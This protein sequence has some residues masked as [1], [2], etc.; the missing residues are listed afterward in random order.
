MTAHKFSKEHKK[1]LGSLKYEGVRNKDSV[2]AFEGMNPDLSEEAKRVGRVQPELICEYVGTGAKAYAERHVWTD[3][4]ELDRLARESEI[5]AKILKK[6]WKLDEK[7]LIMNFSEV[8]R[9]LL[10]SLPYCKKVYKK[11]KGVPGFVA[12]RDLTFEDYAGMLVQ[13][14]TPEKPVLYSQFRSEGHLIAVIQTTKRALCNGNDKIFKG[15]DNVCR[16]LGHYKNRA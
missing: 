11:A 14:A 6:L 5:H 4:A 15:G 1:T 16:P 12:K 2:K 7:G 9:D 3:V 8:E 10:A 13:D